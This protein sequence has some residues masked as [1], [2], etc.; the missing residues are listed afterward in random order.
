MFQKNQQL[1]ELVEA[2]EKGNKTTLN[3]LVETNKTLDGYKEEVCNLNIKLQKKEDEIN[4]LK[5][6]HSFILNKYETTLE[7]KTVEVISFHIFAY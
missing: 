6:N 5:E 1:T 4:K 2:L 3:K 7:T